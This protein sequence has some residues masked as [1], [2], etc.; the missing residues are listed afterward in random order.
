[1]SVCAAKPLASSAVVTVLQQIPTKCSFTWLVCH[2]YHQAI[3][4]LEGQS[5]IPVTAYIQ[6]L[7]HHSIETTTVRKLAFDAHQ[8]IRLCVI[9][10]AE[11]TFS[12]ER[13][14]LSA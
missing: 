1:M 4:C 12:V 14:L 11:K 8:P 7:K 13:F 10:A 3:T 5:F 9:S 2:S 6:L